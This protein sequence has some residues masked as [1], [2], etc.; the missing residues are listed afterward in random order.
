MLRLTL[1]LLLSAERNNLMPNA[2]G[3]KNSGKKIQSLTSA[4]Q[5]LS[6]FIGTG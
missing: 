3:K 6:Q 2:C 4:L 1:T 5:H